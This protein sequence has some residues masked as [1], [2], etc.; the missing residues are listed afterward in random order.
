MDSDDTKTE[1]QDGGKRKQ[2]ANLGA[3]GVSNNKERFE[4]QL[5]GLASSMSAQKEG[6]AASR[7]PGSLRA[8]EAL[9]GSSSLAAKRSRPGAD[10]SRI[11]ATKKLAQ[12]THSRMVSK[13]TMDRFIT[14]R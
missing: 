3:A 2:P 7:Q 8:H 13:E 6:N 5:P 11:S 10:W 9:Y 4:D 12:K 14:A 1:W